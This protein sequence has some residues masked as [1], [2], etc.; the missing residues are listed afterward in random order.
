MHRS[1]S[2]AHEQVE[3][4]SRYLRIIMQH[5]PP[6]IVQAFTFISVVNQCEQ[7]S[8]QAQAMRQDLRGEVQSQTSAEL[9][10]YV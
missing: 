1:A 6:I 8:G 4:N 10:I 2:N 5:E 7:F 3:R 9:T